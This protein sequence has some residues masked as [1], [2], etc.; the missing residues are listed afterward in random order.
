MAIAEKKEQPGSGQKISE[1]VTEPSLQDLFRLIEEQAKNSEIVIQEIETIKGYIRWQKIWSTMRFFLII[2][3][4][5]L[6]LL[7]GL[8]YL[9][10]E[11]KEL[12]D[13]YLSLLRP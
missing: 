10:P 2:L 3:P 6:G 5:V 1:P 11:V 4:I 12:I 7:Y 13:D 9:P 8:F